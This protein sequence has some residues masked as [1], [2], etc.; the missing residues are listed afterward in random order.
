M[1]ER[2]IGCGVGPGGE[3]QLVGEGEEKTEAVRVGF[4]DCA[5]V[6][7]VASV[8]SADIGVASH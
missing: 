7:G 6:L 3:S 2:A 8:E 1:E 5:L 4:F